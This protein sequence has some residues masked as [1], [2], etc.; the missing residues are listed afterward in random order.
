M[1]PIY[2]PIN[3]AHTWEKKYVQLYT[4][5]YTPK[6]KKHKKNPKRR[7]PKKKRTQPKQE[8]NLQKAGIW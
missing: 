3:D 6:A 7:K 4:A 8:T 2:G 5:R 1:M